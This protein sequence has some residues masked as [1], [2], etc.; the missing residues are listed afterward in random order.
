M[1]QLTSHFFSHSLE[2]L[3]QQYSSFFAQP[4]IQL[5]LQNPEHLKIFT[6]TLDSP[7]STTSIISTRLSKFSITGLKY[8]N[9]C[10]P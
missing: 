1:N 7:S 8:T 6:E 10:A 4:I 5:F 3:Q 9:T 2:F